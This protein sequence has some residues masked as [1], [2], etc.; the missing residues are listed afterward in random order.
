MIT[1]SRMLRRRL[2]TSQPSVYFFSRLLLF[3]LHDSGQSMTYDP[4]SAF[5]F[6]CTR[7]GL[8]HISISIV[9][10]YQSMNPNVKYTYNYTSISIKNPKTVS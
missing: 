5:R 9:P 4:L 3:N 10:K 1:W 8:I 6:P 2:S 7:E